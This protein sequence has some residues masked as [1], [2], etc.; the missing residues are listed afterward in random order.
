MHFVL[1]SVVKRVVHHRSLFFERILGVHGISTSSGKTAANNSSDDDTDENSSTDG[2][3]EGYGVG[4][5]VRAGLDIVTASLV[6]ADVLK[7]LV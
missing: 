4:E 5:E 2:G 6:G 7:M 3:C 1:R